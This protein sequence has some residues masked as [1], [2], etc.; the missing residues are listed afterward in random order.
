MGSYYFRGYENTV[1][2]IDT[3]NDFENIYDEKGGR[4]TPIGRIR[5]DDGIYEVYR[6]SNG[7]MAVYKVIC[8]EDG[9]FAL[10][11]DNKLTNELREQYS[12]WK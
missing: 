7:D 3:R 12:F 2:S 11:R 1:D 8:N 5:H 4:L 6:F 9:T 10:N